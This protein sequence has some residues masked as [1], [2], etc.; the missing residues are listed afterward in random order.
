MADKID[1]NE[2]EN[3]INLLRKTAEELQTMSEDFPA[4]FRN[5]SR[6]L[7]SIRMLELNTGSGLH[8]THY[9]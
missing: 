8:S 7:A 4:L 5:T 3:R 9:L 1:L 2:I 6:I